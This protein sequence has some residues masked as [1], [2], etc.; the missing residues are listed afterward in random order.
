MS[1][2]IVGRFLRIFSSNMVTFLTGI[3]ATPVIV[4]VLGPAEYGVYAFLLSA[5]GV[6]ALLADGGIF[7]GIRKYMAESD[8]SP[9]WRAQVF[10]LYARVA[11]VLI[12]LLSVGIFLAVEMDI[13]VRHFGPRY[14]Q[15]F[16]ALAGV[17]AAKQLGAIAR[18]ALMGLN[19]ETVSESLQIL[20]KLIFVAVGLALLLLGYGVIGLLIGLFVGYLTM[21]VLGGIVLSRRL[22]GSWLLRRLPDSFPKREL[23]EFNA[24][25]FV[26]F[27]LYIS[28][29][30]T[31]VL[32]IQWFRDSSETGIYRAALTLAEFLWFV[33]RIAQLTLLHSTSTLWSD[34]AHERITSI[35]AR[36][37][38]YTLAF[39]LLL[40]IGLAA[41]AEPTVRMYYGPEF[42][43]AVGPLLILLPGALGFA[44][45]RPIFAIGQGNA[46]LRPLNYATGA[47]AGINL[48]GN[49]LLIPRYGMYG[50]AVATTTGY[51]SMMVFHVWSA[52][53]IGFNPTIDLRLRRVFVTALISAGAIF[54]LAERITADIY[55]LLVVPPIGF[56][57][58]VGLS[59]ATGVIDSSE[60]NA[61]LERAPIVNNR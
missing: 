17:I 15:Y 19:M 40:V 13:L 55:A 5:M 18:S 52:R 22:D 58:Y 3:L 8:R 60:L 57:V 21:A 38:R 14:D 24:G 56:A 11:I 46:D 42:T 12:S 41:L 34:S 43:D 36:T 23:L 20:N 9:D 2:S 30:H 29:L 10:A 54:L 27:A 51:L 7:D 16:I 32:M 33:P 59:I 1:T 6:L 4:R 50:A 47:A 28:I 39:T 35:S 44:V 26:L 49:L 37:T 53:T 45:A 61:A 25:S 31:D 48:V